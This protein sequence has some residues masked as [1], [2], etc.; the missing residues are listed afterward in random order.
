MALIYFLLYLSFARKLPSSQCVAHIGLCIPLFYCHACGFNKNLCMQ[1]IT[2]YPRWFVPVYAL[3]LT[4]WALAGQH[5]TE[6]WQKCFNQKSFDRPH[7]HTHTRTN[8]HERT[9]FG[10]WTLSARMSDTLDRL[11][12]FNELVITAIIN[13]SIHQPLSNPGRA[14]TAQMHYE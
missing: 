13:Q 12:P 2:S 7:A 8:T 6:V 9:N 4:L 14:A 11:Q 10:Q 5:E 3:P 1:K